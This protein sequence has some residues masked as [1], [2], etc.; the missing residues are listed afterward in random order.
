MQAEATKEHAWLKKLVGEWRFASEC[1]QGPDGEPMRS[2]GKESIRML[3]E[4]WAVGEM[5]G[6]MPDGSPMT[7][8]LTLGFD[9]SKG[10]FV[11][12]WVGSPMSSMF[13]YEGELDEAE[14]RLT[15]NTTGPSC[16][17]GEG[18]MNYQDIVE[19]KPDGTRVMRS[20]MQG[21]N[22]EWAE[23]MRAEFTRA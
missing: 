18:E 15:L 4:L 9:P 6:E 20:R 13:V 1:P 22:G 2:E 12:T 14:N 21:E 5:T 23:F 16:M 8:V 17:G 10:K 11:G 7:A 3:G 19:L